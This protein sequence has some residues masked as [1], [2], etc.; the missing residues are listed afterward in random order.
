MPNKY[1]RRLR[2]QT[3]DLWTAAATAVKQSEGGEREGER[4]R[5]MVSKKTRK[6][7]KLREQVEKPRNTVFFWLGLKK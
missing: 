1:Q 5:E 3:P 2:S 7:V 4:E 6:K